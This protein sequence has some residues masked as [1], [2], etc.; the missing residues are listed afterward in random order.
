MKKILIAEDDLEIAQ[1]E[2]DYLEINGMQARIAADGQTAIDMARAEAYDLLLLDVMLPRKNGFEVCR[3]LRAE[4]DLPILMVTA[5]TESVDKI[6]GLGLGADDYIVK[7]FDPSELVARVKAHLAQ[8]ERLSGAMRAK[9]AAEEITIGEL[10]ILPK[11]FKVSVRGEEVRLPNKEFELLVF[12][13]KHPNQVFSKETLFEQIWG[14]DYVGDSA[15]VTVHINRIREKIE[16]DPSN[17]RYI[18]T[19]WG[20][21]YRMNC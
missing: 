20:A 3:E 18:D 7:P 9:K 12:L 21:G 14:Y 5:K 16:E 1:I 8:V 6:R 2:K 13:A 15:T 4:F 11:A 10:T 17:P 19:I